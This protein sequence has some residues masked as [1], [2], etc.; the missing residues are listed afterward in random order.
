MANYEVKFWLLI[1]YSLNQ[2]YLLFFK[3]LQVCM[4]GFKHPT[5]FWLTARS[6]AAANS[7]GIHYVFFLSIFKIH[8]LT[9]NSKVKLPL[10]FRSWIWSWVKAEKEAWKHNVW[11]LKE[12]VWTKKEEV[13][14]PIYK[15]AKLNEPLV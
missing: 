1:T 15:W 14:G 12:P 8:T 6:I 9:T 10:K 2:S 3:L 13:E 7:F 4:S 5:F 11:C